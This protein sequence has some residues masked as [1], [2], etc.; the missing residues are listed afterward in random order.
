M[1]MPKAAMDENDGAAS[2]KDQ[3]R[4]TGQIGAMQPETETSSMEATPNNH[5]RLGVAATDL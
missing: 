3:V 1:T 2:G 5:L 4:S